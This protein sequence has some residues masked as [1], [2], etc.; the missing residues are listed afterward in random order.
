[1]LLNRRTFVAAT[2]AAGLAGPALAAVNSDFFTDIE[3]KVGGRIGVFAICFSSPGPFI[4]WR[5][6]ERFPMCSTFKAMAAAALLKR[7]DEGREHLYRFVPYTESDL[8]P[9]APTTRAHVAQG[10]MKLGDL[11]Q[12]MLQLSDNG[13]ANLIL[14]AIGGP[15]GWTRFVR[16]LTDPLSRLDRTEPTLNTSIPGDPRDTT[17]PRVMAF[18]LVRASKVLKDDTRQMLHT[19]ML[20]CKT[21]DAR[22]RR[23]LPA[24]WEV[25]DKTGTGDNG[26]ANDIG[27][28]YPPDGS[29]IVI[30]CYLT[31][32][33]AV[34]A[35]AREAAIAQ[36]GALVGQLLGPAHG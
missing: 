28:A 27:I 34:S 21:G 7:V 2:A 25:A 13:A 9:Y 33:T 15:P 30:S 12:A 4:A 16:S 26:T 29:A 24:G 1:M 10:G 36:V 23:G 14:T 22:L 6:D 8:L 11:C 31:G 5:S 35:D 3:A 20:G 19:W 17:T 32:A 18:D